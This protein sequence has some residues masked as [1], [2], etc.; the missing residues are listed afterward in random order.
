MKDRNSFSSKFKI[1]LLMHLFHRSI[2]QLRSGIIFVFLSILLNWKSTMCKRIKVLLSIYNFSPS[3]SVEVGRYISKPYLSLTIFLTFI[4][5]FSLF[6]FL[7]ANWI[8]WYYLLCSTVVMIQR[9]LWKVWEPVSKFHLKE[10]K[11][12][13]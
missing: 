7:S 2:R 11:N 4:Y 13:I 12:V 1:L 6:I 10:I 8:L 5:H 9:M 3:I